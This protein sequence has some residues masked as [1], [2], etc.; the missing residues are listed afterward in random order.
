MKKCGRCDRMLAEPD[1]YRRTASRDGLQT[2]CKVCQKAYMRTY[3]RPERMY[4]RGQRV[5]KRQYELFPEEDN[6]QWV[7][8][9][10]NN[11]NEVLNVIGMLRRRKVIRSVVFF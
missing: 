10:I 9:N 6:S 11:H 1:F 4:P 8:F 5:D 7:R 2:W 3:E